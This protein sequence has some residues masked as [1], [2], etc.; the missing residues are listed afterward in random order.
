MKFNIKKGIIIGLVG[1]LASCTGPR[2]E[3]RELELYS[4]ARYPYIAIC[5]NDGREIFRYVANPDTNYCSEI[6][7]PQDYGVIIDHKTG[8]IITR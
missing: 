6:H 8:K 5:K 2:Q 7:S 4:D 3:V 1:L